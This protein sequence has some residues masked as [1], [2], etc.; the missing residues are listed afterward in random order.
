MLVGPRSP[1]LDRGT[2]PPPAGAT[3]GARTFGRGLKAS[4][5][6]PEPSLWI[7]L[8]WNVAVLPQRITDARCPPR[9]LRSFGPGKRSMATAPKS[10]TDARAP[11]T[12][13]LRQ[14]SCSDL[15]RLVYRLDEETLGVLDKR[16]LPLDVPAEG[17]QS[18]V[19]TST[20]GPGTVHR[21]PSWA[22]R[23]LGQ[24]KAAFSSGWAVV[25]CPGPRPSSACV[26][27]TRPQ[28]RP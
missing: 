19:A 12:M 28:H 7:D 9:V 17:Q 6:D 10:T 24:A 11:S 25:K 21:G 20:V 13:L 15:T 2:A 23:T 4:V 16:S 5:G 22:D 1:S 27:S 14:P 18:L 3:R 26:L 8:P